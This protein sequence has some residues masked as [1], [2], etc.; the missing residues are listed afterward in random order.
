MKIFKIICINLLVL[1]IFFAI[2]E[3]ILVRGY[4]KE[5]PDDVYHI[6]RIA[7]KSLLSPDKFRKPEGLNY[8][9]RPI[10]LFGCSFAYGQGLEDKDTFGYKLSQFAKRPVYNY[11]MFGKGFQHALYV[12]RHNYIDKSVKNPEYAIYVFIEDQIR[13]IYS[14]VCMGDFVGQPSYALDGALNL[15]ETKDYYPIYRQFYTFYYVNNLIYE[16]FLKHDYRRH[17]R[18]VNAYLNQIYRE[19]KRRYPDIKFVVLLY[20]GKDNFGL[21]FYGLNEQIIL[22]NTDELVEK[23]LYDPEY[24]ISSTNTHPNGLAWD[25]VVP[26]LA[27][28]LNL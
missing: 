1:L 28:E 23:N 4:K 24:Q 5:N 13:R 14:N 2:F 19:L 12:L 3:L 9:K 10:L 25:L 20:G 7:Y 11:S 21:D 17:N 18:Y 27:S 15:Y 6:G 26:K 8:T 22:L 16:K